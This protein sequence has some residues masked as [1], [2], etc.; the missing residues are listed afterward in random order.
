MFEISRTWNPNQ[1]ER[2][3][4]VDISLW[5]HLDSASTCLIIRMLFLLSFHNFAL[6]YFPIS[7]RCFLVYFVSS[8][9]WSHALIFCSWFSVL[10][11]CSRC[12]EAANRSDKG[13]S[14]SDAARSSQQS[15]HLLQRL[16]WLAWNTIP[17]GN[18]QVLIYSSCCWCFWHLVIVWNCCSYFQLYRSRRFCSLSN[19]LTTTHLTFLCLHTLVLFLIL[20]PHKKIH[21][22]VINWLTCQ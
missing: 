5:C 18:E 15:G 13:R 1:P 9:R 17:A 7:T 3:H 6:K 22:S 11:M 20:R 16:K 2:A 21:D 8:K 12:H 19:I 14:G 4:F 10:T